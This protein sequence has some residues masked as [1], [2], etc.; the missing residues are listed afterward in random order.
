MGVH[1]ERTE[2]GVCVREERERERDIYRETRTDKERER[3]RIISEGV[4]GLPLTY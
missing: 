4:G 2:G 3:K 1:R